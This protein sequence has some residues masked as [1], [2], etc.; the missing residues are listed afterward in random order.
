MT[1]RFF[2]DGF[3]YFEFSVVLSFLYMLFAMPLVV[4]LLEN[5]RI[6]EETVNTLFSLACWLIVMGIMAMFEYRRGHGE[7]RHGQFSIAKSAV[8]KLLS[9]LFML[10]PLGLTLA[11]QAVIHGRIARTYDSVLG[12]LYRGFLWPMFAVPPGSPATWVHGAL[13]AT[14]VWLLSFGIIFL[15]FYMGR[16]RFETEFT[17]RFGRKPNKEAIDL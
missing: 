15:G 14:A 8:Q 3:L 10:L 5:T 1:K 9:L 17:T 12:A 13:A 2:A 6:S 11:L 16:R 7:Q 4:P